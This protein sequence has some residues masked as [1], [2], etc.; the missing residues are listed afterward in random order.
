M[1][2]RSSGSGVST[3]PL[4]QTS[5]SRSRSKLVIVVGSANSSNSRRLV[6]LAERNG[7]TAYLVD[8]ASD[9]LVEWLDGVEVVGLTAG[10]SAP[11]VLVDEVISRIA[12]LG[13]VEVVEHEVTRENVRFTLP[14]AV[15]QL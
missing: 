10:A 14:A 12:A 9:V 13:P 2:V 1:S 11:P 7:T 15:R 6:E 5:S 8:R 4:A 3:Q